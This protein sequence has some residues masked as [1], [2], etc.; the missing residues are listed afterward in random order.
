MF[1]FSYSGRTKGIVGCFERDIWAV[2]EVNSWWVM[3]VV[4]HEHFTP[5]LNN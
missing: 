2:A 3:F 5:V 4:E 1:I